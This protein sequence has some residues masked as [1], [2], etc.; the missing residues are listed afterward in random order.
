MSLIGKLV[1]GDSGCMYPEREGQIISEE[2]NRWGEMYLIAW[3]DGTLENFFKHQI[4]SVFERCGVGVY[5][6]QRE[7]VKF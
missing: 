4:K 7:N 6:K 3:E 2:K 1:I 5:Y